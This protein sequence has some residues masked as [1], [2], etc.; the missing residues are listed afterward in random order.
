MINKFVFS[1]LSSILIWFLGVCSFL[2]S[3]YIPIIDNLDLQANIV[4][5]FALIPS[6]CLG[7]YLFYKKSYIKPYVLAI[8]SIVVIT[9]LDACITVPV[10]L[11]PIGINHLEFFTDPKFYA[12]AIELF[13]IIMYFGNHLNNKKIK[14]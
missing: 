9:I 13:L 7:T 1:V 2:L 4:L 10:F 3:F 12:I 14:A 6:A 5:A 11:I 8:I